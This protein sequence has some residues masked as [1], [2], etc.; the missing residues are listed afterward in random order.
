MHLLPIPFQPPPRP[1]HDEPLK[2]L[3]AVN[4]SDLFPGKP[5]PQA[6]PTAGVGCAAPHPRPS[7][8]TVNDI[9]QA[10]PP[11]VM[12][13]EGDRT[14]AHSKKPD[15][16]RY[17]PKGQQDKGASPKEP[18]ANPNP[19]PGDKAQAQAACKPRTRPRYS[20][21]GRKSN[22][23]VK[24]NKG[25]NS[26]PNGDLGPSAEKADPEDEA[27]GIQTGDGGSLLETEFGLDGPGTEGNVPL[28]VLS[29]SP[30]QETNQHMNQRQEPE[31]AEESWDSLFNDNGDC[32]DP[33]LI[34]EIS[35]NAGKKESTQEPR[36]NNYNWDTEQEAELELRDDELSHIV[37]IYDFPSEFKME[38]LLRAFHSYQQRGFDIQWVD[39]QHALGLFSSP[40][41]A[42]D[43]LRSKHPLMKVRP[44]SQASD[45]TKAKARSCSDYLLPAKERPET[46]AVLARRLVIGAL[47]VRSPQSPDEKEADRRKL[48]VAREQKRLV[49]KQR[50]DAW[51]GK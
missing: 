42:R 46:S 27:Q 20:D 3:P 16:E 9:T 14:P 15:M 32:L 11:A 26:L 17:I 29:D 10:E 40:I 41:A 24:R 12:E 44:L 5:R 13:Q 48:Q 31:Q 23:K 6:V 45:V 1:N 47:G 39:E 33:H 28:E 22:S 37:E 38:D 35:L 18:P 4:Q 51:E 2:S 30:G 34:E 25:A 43:A 36:F 8:V 21:K 49:A 7:S 19:S 50:E